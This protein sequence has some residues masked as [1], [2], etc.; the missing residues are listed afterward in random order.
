M[1][2]RLFGATT[3]SSHRD[4]DVQLDQSGEAGDGYSEVDGLGVEIDFF[5]LCIGTDHVVLA[6]EKE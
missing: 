5:D 2:R 3:S 1:P 6:P 4:L